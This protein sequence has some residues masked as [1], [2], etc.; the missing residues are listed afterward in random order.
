MEARVANI[1]NIIGIN[2]GRTGLFNCQ[3]YRVRTINVKAA[4]IWLLAP[5]IGHIIHPACLDDPV[6]GSV[7]FHM[8]STM[9]GKIAMTVAKYLFSNTLIF[10][11]LPN[12]DKTNR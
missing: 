4:N 1:T 3:K 5:N 7:T 2:I 6:I 10:E 12:S 9:A 11:A 8:V